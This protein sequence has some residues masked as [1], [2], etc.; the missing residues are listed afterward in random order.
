MISIK[1]VYKEMLKFGEESASRRFSP[2]ELTKVLRLFV[3][4]NDIKIKTHRD[5]RV[6]RNQIVISGCYDPMEDESNFAS[7]LIYVTYSPTQK[8]IYI[9]NIDWSQLCVDLIECTGHEIV[10]QSQYRAR[11]YDI[12]STIFV[13]LS[14][15]IEKRTDQEYLGNE[16]EIEAFG[17]SIAAEMYLKLTPKTLT[18]KHITKSATF[19]AYNA[20]FGVDHPVVQKLLEFV[21]RYYSQLQTNNK[22][23]NIQQVQLL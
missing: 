7:I 1:K 3:G 11:E 5:S 10:H 16:D 14:S 17:Y 22:V 12:G 19:E 9:R 20:A 2:P 6:D 23:I 4:N 13:S 15:D 8:H 21:Y 18:H